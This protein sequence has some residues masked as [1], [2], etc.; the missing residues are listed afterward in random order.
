MYSQY[1]CSVWFVDVST[2]VKEIW[3]YNQPDDLVKVLNHWLYRI[4]TT[5]GV[6]LQNNAHGIY[7]EEVPQPGSLSFT[8][9]TILTICQQ[10]FSRTLTVNSSNTSVCAV[11]PWVYKRV[12]F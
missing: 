6:P 7:C 11:S 10:H 3:I 1:T 4:E 8:S 5:A 9:I 2:S 12:F